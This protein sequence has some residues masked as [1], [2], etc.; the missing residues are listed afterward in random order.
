M[1]LI[2]IHVQSKNH[3]AGCS[4]W[5]TETLK[6]YSVSFPA[7]KTAITKNRN[8]FHKLSQL[9]LYENYFIFLG[10]KKKKDLFLLI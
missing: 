5:T 3:Q 9:F 6:M 1:L 4:F 7:V 8:V 10:K 2:Q